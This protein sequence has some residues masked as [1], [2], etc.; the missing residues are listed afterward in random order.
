VATPAPGRAPWPAVGSRGALLGALAVSVSLSVACTDDAVAPIP[1]PIPF[2]DL[3]AGPDRTCAIRDDGQVL[4]W[5]RRLLGGNGSNFALN[6]TPIA[7]LRARAVAVGGDHTCALGNDGGAVCWGDNRYGQGGRADRAEADRPRP[8]E[9]TLRFEQLSAGA[10]HTCARTGGDDIWCWGFGGRGSIGARDLSSSAAP[11][12]LDRGRRAYIDFQA[13][14]YHGCAVGED[15]DVYCWGWNRY[16]QLGVGVFVDLGSPERVSRPGPYVAVFTGEHHTCALE[17]DGAAWCWGRGDAGQLGHGS[18][19]GSST[20]VP[21]AGGLRFSR[22][23]LGLQHT[24]GLD[25]AGGT[26]CWGDNRYGRLGTGRTETVV[27]SPTAV[28]S[29]QRFARISSGHL[30]TCAIS[31]EGHAYCWGHGGYG[32]LGNGGIL[33][34]PTPQ[35]VARPGP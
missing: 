23:A 7:D 8:V 6:P 3:A 1:A 22:L 28:E 33:N 17:P 32:Q 30:H 11:L 35:P 31:L 19:T 34:A 10:V 25:M 4:C 26:H 20:P 27:A 18:A 16:G 15:R 9:D 21:V 13:A 2:L 14:G 24:C 12:L 29:D 5:G